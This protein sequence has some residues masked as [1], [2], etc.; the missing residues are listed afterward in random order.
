LHAKNIACVHSAMFSIRLAVA[1]D[2]NALATLK[3]TTFR[4]TFLDGFKIQY[5]AGDLARF[6]AEHYAPEKVLV[7]LADPKRATWIAEAAD[8]RLLGYAQ[9]GPCKLPHPDVGPRAGELYQLYLLDDAQ[10]LGLGKQ[11]LQ[12]AL[13]W[14]A[15][16][17]PG[18]QWLG[19]WSKNERAQSIYAKIG[20]TKVGEYEFPVGTWRDH[21][22]IFRRD[23]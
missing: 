18:P 11:L 21:E 8:G 20:F 23:A 2:A 6:E 17:Y 7:E 10:G 19:V 13:D 9:C 5:P 1:A 16:H 12:L 22:F 3:L 14:L 15:R 4:Q